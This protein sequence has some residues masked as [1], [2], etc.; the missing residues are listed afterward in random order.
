[1][2]KT[3]ALIVVLFMALQLLPFVPQDVFA[4]GSDPAQLISNEFP[5]SFDL[6][7]VSGRSYVT[8]VRSQAPFGTCWSFATVAAIESSILG[9]G[10]KGAD[11]KP[12]DPATLNLSEKQLAWFSAMPLKDPGNPQNGEGQFIADFITEDTLVEFMNRGG[13]EFFSASALAQGI[14]PANESDDPYFEYHG[15]DSIVDHEWQDGD[16]SKYSYSI[17]D[18]WSIPDEY[19]FV[20]SYDVREIN[21]LPSPSS[22]DEEGYYLYNEAGTKAIKEELMALRAVEISFCADT[23]MPGRD[24]KTRFISEHWAH[25]TYIP[26]QANHEVTII[27]WDDNYSKDNFLQGSEEVMLKDGSKKT[28]EKAPPADGAWLVKNSWGS[29]NVNFPDEGAGN[30]GVTD[31]N[32][33]HTGYFWLSYYD[34]SIGTPVTYKVANEDKGIDIID[35]H[36]YMQL[37]DLPSYYS[38][39]E[40]KMCNFFTA[41]CSRYLEQVACF[42]AKP[43]TTVT[44][45][46]YLVNDLCHSPEEGVKVAEKTAT[47]RYG[48]YHKENISDFD[49]LIDTEGK[50]RNALLIP[51]WEKYAVCVTQ[52]TE[53]GQY[54]V[55]FPCASYSEGGGIASFKGIIN[56]SESWLYIDG[57]WTD[58]AYA[59]S[60]RA[61]IAHAVYPDRTED[62]YAS[63]S[64]DNFPI[65]VYCRKAE[66]NCALSVAGGSYLTYNT[67]SAGSS[68]LRVEMHAKNNSLPN[69]PASDV[70]WSL[71]EGGQEC[72]ELDDSIGSGKAKITAKN[73][74]D[75]NGS[76]Y[77]T[78]KGIGTAAVK[79]HVGKIVILSILMPRDPETGGE[80]RVFTYTGEPIC[81]A[82]GVEN[83]FQPLT[84]GEDYEFIYDNNVKC[85]LA[86]IMVDPISDMAV[87]SDG[88]QANFLIVP[89]KAVIESAEASGDRITVKLADQSESGLT[90]YLVEYREKGAE[91]WS[92]VS[93]NASDTKAVLKDLKDST[94]YEI[95]ARGYIECEGS[96]W[97]GEEANFGRASETAVV[98]TEGAP[99]RSSGVW[100]AAGGGTAALAGVAAFLFSKKKKS[101]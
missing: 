93:L 55:N 22:L 5:A 61:D 78:V 62:D 90:G 58:Y 6:R 74:D 91:E 64:Y 100:I 14:G 83:N 79:V 76:L 49:I 34:Q 7:N 1:M 96:N 25:Y 67:Q 99:S 13:N 71:D 59:D 65:K 80:K 16:L 63:L 35:Q 39:E 48:G 37:A 84:E 8:P 69:I 15:K 44:Y 20:S 68:T 10:L 43:G 42:T 60:V 98:S 53:D 32:N 28:I 26:A 30:W 87:V 66:T 86:S 2:K 18:D 19:R 46:I 92:S 12:A 75:G 3:I 11:G 85:G 23:S 41:N 24:D 4:E 56:A 94:E 54:A 47:Y 9:A 101:A 82:V 97:F 57:E 77:V 88:M 51:M 17:L 95:R 52:K 27:G 31:Q 45:E 70:I 50:G 38:D 73:V 89:Q 81:P 33:V 40:I 72:I 21:F 29:G 36:D